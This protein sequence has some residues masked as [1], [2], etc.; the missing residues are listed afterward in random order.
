MKLKKQ[1]M[2][3]ALSMLFA[4]EAV[5][6]SEQEV[7]NF[8]GQIEALMNR[9][10]ADEISGFYKFYSDK[11]ARFVKVSK[12][13]DPSN[14]D[15]VIAEE[16][17]DMD[18]DEYISYLQ[19]I[20]KTPA[21]YAYTLTIDSIKVNNANN[22]ATVMVTAGDSSMSYKYDAERQRDYET[23]V[24]TTSNCNYSLA[25]KSAHYYI[26]GMNCLEKINKTAVY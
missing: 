17:K 15:K 7:R 14:Q 4:N 20:V 10:K 25:Y 26:L 22:T 19:D 23:Y 24:L 3:L 21:R 6:G 13:V 11:K 1:F 16:S 5:A 2:I 9:R 18:V 12:L 8:M